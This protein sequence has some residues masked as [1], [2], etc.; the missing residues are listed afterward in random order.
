MQAEP[1]FEILAIWVGN[2]LG[3][4]SFHFWGQPFAIEILLYQAIIAALFLT[5]VLL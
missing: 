5:E 3:R 4:L 1:I 2:F